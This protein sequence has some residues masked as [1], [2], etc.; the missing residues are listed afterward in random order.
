GEAE[1]RERDVDM[2]SPCF[3][4]CCWIGFIH[5]SALSSTTR[6]ISANTCSLLNESLGGL[7]FV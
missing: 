1:Q 2:A 7:E 5:G 3:F 4:L 6:S